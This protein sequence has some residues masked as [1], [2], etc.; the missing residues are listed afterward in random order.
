[1]SEPIGYKAA[2]LLAA[3]LVNEARIQGQRTPPK[4]LVEEAGSINKGFTV[5]FERS[6]GADC[7]LDV[8]YQDTHTGSCGHNV[9][10]PL[11]KVVWPSTT[12]TVV[13]A[14]AAVTLFEEVIKLGALIQTVLDREQVLD[15]P[16]VSQGDVKKGRGKL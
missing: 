3:N 5:K 11:V 6:W 2:S 1:M 10:K 8:V 13:G 4:L 14:L 7:T 15:K 12:L 9:L 16:V